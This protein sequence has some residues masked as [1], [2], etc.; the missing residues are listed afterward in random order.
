M[1]ST[2]S[3]LPDVRRAACPSFPRQQQLAAGLQP[4]LRF[5]ALLDGRGGCTDLDWSGV[6]QWAA[7]SGFLWVHLERDAPEAQEWVRHCR[8]IP[9]TVAEL[10]LAEDSRPRVEAMGDGLLLVLRGVNLEAEEVELVP[11]HVWIDAGRML[12]LRDRGHSL[13][14]LRDIRLNLVAGGGPRDGADLLVQVCVKTVR[15]MEPI[16]DQM[17]SEVTELEEQVGVLAPH[18]MRRRLGDLRRRAIHLRRYLHPQREA[19]FHLQN[20]TTALLDADHRLRLSVVIDAL[21]RFLE[22][23]DAIRERATVV[24]EDLSAMINEQIAQTSYRLTALATILLTPGLI[25]GMLGAN[26]GGIPG[27]E[28]SW[29]FG[30]LAVLIAGILAVQSYIFRRLRWL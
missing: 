2:E 7:A 19:L 21:I 11:L 30:S 12:T 20:A 13:C 5:A 27:H 17:D 25:V 3:P 22:D 26:V 29:G 23:L 6:S 15:D 4:G 28:S 14:A 24:H 9:P 16:V 10:L 18:Q 1:A 8:D